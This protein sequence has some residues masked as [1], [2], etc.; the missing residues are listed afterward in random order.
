MIHLS[1]KK[2]VACEGGVPPFT[3][4]QIAKYMPQVQ[5]WELVDDKKIVKNYKFKDFAEAMQFVNKVAAIAESEGHHPDIGISWNK[6][7]LELMTHAI[8]GL[9]EN[10]FIVA[11]KVDKILT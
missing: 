1:D 9:S 10:D 6:V 2:C 3:K 7:K 5:G 11:A 4:T 8:H